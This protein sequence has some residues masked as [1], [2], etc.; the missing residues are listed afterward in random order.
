L[1][2]PAIAGGIGAAVATGALV[3]AIVQFADG[4][5]D[6]FVGM[7][8]R[9]ADVNLVLELLLVLGLTFGMRLARAG[10]VEAHRRNQTMWVLVNA[11]LVV[12]VMLPSLLRGGPGS[13]RDFSHAV[14]PVTW[15][16]AVL[17]AAT[18]V[19]GLWLVLQMNDVLPARWHVARWK[20]LMRVTL[21]GYWGVALLGLATYLVWYRG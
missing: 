5:G 11:A 12:A 2:R 4:Y 17:G 13:L 20:T 6:G 1:N 7:G 8:T 10:N 9:I 19:A 18:L 21:A 15:L 16:H 14:A 3:G